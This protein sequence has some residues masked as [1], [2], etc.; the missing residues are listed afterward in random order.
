VLTQIAMLP[1]HNGDPT[2][3]NQTNHSA[4]GTPLATQTSLDQHP[5]PTPATCSWMPHHLNESSLATITTHITITTY[6]IVLAQRECLL[7][8]LHMLLDLNTNIAIL[9]ETKLTKGLQT[10]HGYRYN[11]FA[12]STV[13]PSQGGATLIWQM[14]KTQWILERTHVVSVNSISTTLVFG[15]NCRLLLVP[16][17]Q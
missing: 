1:Y 14:V 17:L 3:T 13:S 10:K 4:T 9:T 16:T 11:V 7:K 2:T 15:T 5:P 6:N 12:T 8:A